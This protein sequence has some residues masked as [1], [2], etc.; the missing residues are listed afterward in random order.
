M[1][2]RITGTS[3]EAIDRGNRTETRGTKV[4]KGREEEWIR[5][6]PVFGSRLRCPRQRSLSDGGSEMARTK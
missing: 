4:E 2:I 1:G 6:S 5:R 3:E